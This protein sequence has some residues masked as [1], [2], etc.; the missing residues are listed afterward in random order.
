LD[1]GEGPSSWAKKKK[2]DKHHRD[3][4][5]AAA[6]E[7]KAARPKNNPPKDHFEKL[8]EASC[9]N[10]KVPVKHTLNDG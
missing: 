9:N 6:I 8:L 1:D 10:H 3:D 2:K 5:L 7:R 4:N